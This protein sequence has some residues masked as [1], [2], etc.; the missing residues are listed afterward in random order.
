M[1]E[2]EKTTDST[3]I[4]EVHLDLSGNYDCPRCGTMNAAIGIYIY[5]EGEPFGIR[6]CNRPLCK[7]LMMDYERAAYFE[8]LE[9][10]SSLEKERK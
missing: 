1:I 3:T 4:R 5:Y 6:Y 7:S 2:L 8:E 10:H 9:R